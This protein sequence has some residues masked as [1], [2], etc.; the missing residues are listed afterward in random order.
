MIVLFL[1]F[2]FSVILFRKRKHALLSLFASVWFVFYFLTTHLLTQ[3]SDYSRI[4]L[5]FPYEIIH[6]EFGLH[7]KNTETFQEWTISN[8]SIW[9]DDNTF[10]VHEGENDMRVGVGLWG[11]KSPTYDTD[12]ARMHGIRLETAFRVFRVIR[13]I[14]ILVLFFGFYFLLAE[15]IK[16]GD[17]WSQ[18]KKA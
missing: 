16:R 15:I 14:L 4:P 9:F 10:W 13:A 3:G 12:N 11:E 6:S 2:L 18:A 17:R 7:L 5:R 8:D 1:C